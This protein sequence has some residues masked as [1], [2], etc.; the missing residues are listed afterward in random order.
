MG[1][2]LLVV[3]ETPLFMEIWWKM[4]EIKKDNKTKELCIEKIKNGLMQLP[5]EVRMKL[6]APYAEK[7][8]R[9]ENSATYQECL[10]AQ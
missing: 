10:H 9:G 4:K 7:Y 3:D 8:M 5:E 1:Y 6:L 2:N